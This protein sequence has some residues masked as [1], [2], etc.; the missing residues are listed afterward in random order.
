MAFM[1]KGLY[2]YNRH[3]KNEDVLATTALLANRL[4]KLYEQ[5]AT[6][7]WAWFEGYLTY[8]NS[9]LPEA[10]LCAYTITGNDTYKDIA[11]KS[12]DFLVSK[13]FCEDGIKVISNRSW[14]IKGEICE[15]YGEQPIDVAYTVITLRKFHDIFKDRKYLVKMEM[16]FNWFLGNNHLQ[17]IIYNPC[18]GGCFDGLE[19]HNVNLN[20]GAESTVSYLMARMMIDKYFG[21]EN[22]LYHRR[23]SRS[24]KEKL[25]VN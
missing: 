24:Y 5:E 23:K 17:Q 3:E 25:A 1:I 10:L 2:Y 13:T 21:H 11:K 12:F 6:A 19:E 15:K 18:T 9:V 14:H 16:A 22:E 7:D 4:V 20:Q 8:A